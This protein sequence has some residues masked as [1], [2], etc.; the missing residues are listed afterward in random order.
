MRF[1]AAINELLT[2]SAE[3]A[4]TKVFVWQQL[5]DL[6][7]QQKENAVNPAAESAW[8]W[9]KAL[10]PEVPIAVRLRA[11]QS[12]AGIC[13]SPDIVRFLPGTCPSLGPQF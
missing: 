11:S 2:Q 12:L 10:R 1:E 6:L 8:R 5:I 9:V 7:A 13:S 3:T 4:E